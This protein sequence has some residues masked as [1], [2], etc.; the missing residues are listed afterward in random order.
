MSLT[1]KKEITKADHSTDH[2]MIAKN[3]SLSPQQRIENHQ[4]ALNLVQELKKAGENFY[5]KSQRASQKNT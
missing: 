2:Q 4:S 1:A 3:L 5:G